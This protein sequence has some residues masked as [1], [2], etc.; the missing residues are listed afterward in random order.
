MPFQWLRDLFAPPEP[1]PHWLFG[2]FR[3]APPPP[4]AIPK[5]LLYVGGA[6]A[7]GVIW[8]LWNWQRPPPPPSNPPRYQNR[9]E[10][11]SDLHW[12]N[13]RPSLVARRPEPVAS[14][15]YPQSYTPPAAPRRGGEDTIDLHGLYAQDAIRALRMR[16]NECQKCGILI[17][18]VIVGQGKNSP[19]GEP[20]LKP[21][22]G[23]W[24]Q[25]YPRC[26]TRVDPSNAGR[27]I[28][29]IID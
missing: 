19:N 23:E 5:P 20:V 26:T 4:P 11:R 15:R 27:Y 9:Y 1:P 17:L 18:I 13:D 21:V 7:V 16:L 24:L 2:L 25:R 8:A 14:S 10:N 3:P 29:T 28:C 22:I 6:I 12:L